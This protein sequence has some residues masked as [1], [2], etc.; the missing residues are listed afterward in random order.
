MRAKIFR[1]NRFDFAPVKGYDNYARFLTQLWSILCVVSGR[2]YL[3]NK[4]I[5]IIYVSFRFRAVI[6]PTK[7][8]FSRN[9]TCCIISTTWLVSLL[10]VLPYVFVLNFDGK[11]CNE[12]WPADDYRRAYTACLFVFQVTR[13]AKF[14]FLFS[15]FLP[16]K[17]NCCTNEKLIVFSEFSFRETYTQMIWRGF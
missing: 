4:V 3:N 2:M 7:P 12:K 1:G 10:L 9:Q 8:R 16:Q 14:S 17:L 5:Y 13:L 15:F 11:E 6:Y